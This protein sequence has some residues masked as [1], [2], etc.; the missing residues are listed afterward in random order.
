MGDALRPSDDEFS[1]VLQESLKI[2]NSYLSA[3]NEQHQIPQK[4][5]SMRPLVSQT[6]PFLGDGLAS[7]DKPIS[8]ACEEK[9][10]PSRGLLINGRS[11]WRT[12]KGTCDLPPK[13]LPRQLLLAIDSRLSVELSEDS[14]LSDWPGV[15][16]L[17]GYDE[18]NYLS[19]LYFAWAY[20]LSARWVELLN[21]SADHECHMHYTT[22]RGEGRFPQSNYQPTI[23]I[24]IGDDACEEEVVWWWAIL[25]SDD[26]WDATVKYNGH[27]YLSP[28]SISA[29]KVGFTLA[30]K[31]NLSAK[32]E[33]LAK[34]EPPLSE[35]A[36]DYLSGF[37]VRHRLY[38]QC[39]VAL[40]GVLF[41]PFLKGR[42]LSLPLP[43]QASWPSLTRC[44][45]DSP[46]SISDLLA[47]HK[48]LLPKYMTLSSNIWGLRSLLHS[49]FF[50]PDIECNLVSAWLNSA[51]A[52]INSISP[53]ELPAFLAT[54]KPILGILWLGA[55]LAGS[56][57]NVLR[58]IR[59]GLVALDLPASAWARTA[60]TFLTSEMETNNSEA[61][62]RDDE[63]RLSF[64][65]ACEGHDRP[66]IWPWKPFGKTQ[67]CDTDLTVRQHAQCGHCLEYESWEWMLT[68]D[69]SIRDFGIDNSDSPDQTP[70]SV[71]NVAPVALGDYKD[72]FFSQ[73]L[74]EGATR[75]IFE[76]LRSTGY[77]LSEKPIYQHSWIDLE[78]TDGEDEPEAESDVESW[79]GAIE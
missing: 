34:S 40:A 65:T 55:I 2:W 57:N 67:L 49:T 43:R 54:R 15:Q 37:C 20:I 63:C 56:A 26:C 21:C 14:P 12:S 66:P 69:D 39:S 73:M 41:I 50:N 11:T 27:M 78:D 32:S 68:N 5:I 23:Q 36:L 42:T 59:I 30:T 71:P 72:D 13:V 18:G 53:N 6:P 10:S 61:I 77:P 3:G 22:D 28:W 60:Q 31:D 33:S 48:E 24:D 47:K 17:S 70:H 74:S 58:D 9:E 8:F 7:F 64:I 25:S 76:W 44:V 16:G 4:A 19:V 38:A 45:N 51:F 29:K 46:V 62:R 35:T 79:L 52:I 75:G 1:E